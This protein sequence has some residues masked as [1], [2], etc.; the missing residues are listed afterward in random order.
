MENFKDL[1]K[2]NRYKSVESFNNATDITSS[3]L[4]IVRLD[5]NVMDIYLGRTKVTHSDLLKANEEL[6]KLIDSL[7]VKVNEIDIDNKSINSIKVKQNTH[8][9]SILDLKSDIKA[10]Q[11]E[12]IHIFE[13]LD[14]IR[15]KLSNITGDNESPSISDIANL[16]QN[17]DDISKELLDKIKNNLSEI[18]KLKTKDVTL[19]EDISGIEKD[20]K[21][22]QSEDIHIFEILNGLQSV[23][24]TILSDIEFIK[25][26]NENINDEILKLKEKIKH[27]TGVNVDNII[28]LEE[29]LVKVEARLDILEKSD[30][31]FQSKIDEI[32]FDNKSIKEDVKKLQTF[33]STTNENIKLLEDDIQNTKDNISSLES[34]IQDYNN[35]FETLENNSNIISENIKSLENQIEELAVVDSNYLDEFNNIEQ[36][37][38]ELSSID[39]TL[40]QDIELLKSKDDSSIPYDIIIAGLDG[41]LGAGN[42]NNGDT[43]PAGTNIYE[44]LQN[45]LCRELFPTNIKTTVASATASMNN[46]ILSLDKS[47]IIEVGTLV[48]LISG[49]TNESYVNKVNSKIENIEYGYSTQNNNKQE[50]PDKYIEK[51]CI[52]EIKDNIY[53]ISASISGFTADTETNIK[54]TP[55]SKT[56][57]G[58]AALD[59]TI[60]GCVIEGDN[61]I[62]INATGASYSYSANAID[63]IYYC[64]NLGKTN[65]IQ[66]HAGIGSVSGTTEK[67]TKSAE[68]SVSGKYKYFLGYSDNTSYNQFDSDSIRAL[69]EKSDWLNINSTTE[70]VGVSDIEKSNGKSIVIACP[71]KY[72]LSSIDTSLG[73]SMI[74]LFTSQ[75]EIDVKTGEIYTKYNV[76]VYPITN[77]TKIDYKNVK[78]TKK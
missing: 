19:I 61:K 5:E 49:S 8:S 35:K 27:L 31:T 15:K 33:E 17:I 3:T 12:D 58:G 14:E 52:A 4:S 71:T 66:Y 62:T 7:S 75:G 32:D 55:E 72:K 23:S 25:K 10:L 11:S 18:N 56:T 45:I 67:P 38:N 53:T 47:G 73:N 13:I 68:A 63:K 30:E 36:K 69:T 22:L 34:N 6:K 70:V 51:E 54:V 77:N 28:S 24:K 39:E 65:E 43:I 50:F 26:D 57:E 44:I 74:E 59:E 78:I 46:L 41:K 42:Y 1:V 9:Q 16:K 64:S 76:Y 20:I 37:I 2:F 48:K 60:L 29:T 21:A 40:Q